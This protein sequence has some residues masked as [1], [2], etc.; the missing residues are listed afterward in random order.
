MVIEQQITKAIIAGIKEL[1]G[2]D[3]TANQVQLQK[4]KKEFKGHLTLVVFP[5]LRQS[6]KS[7]EQTAQEIGAY[8]VAHEPAVAAFNVI[9]GFLNLTVASACWID[10]LNGIAAQPAYGLTPVTEESPLIMIEY[11]SPNTNKPLH[12]G[13]VRNN[14]LGYSL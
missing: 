3:V 8:L 13:H 1:Y 2:A 14:L 4:T 9:K 11:S 6:K 7:T 10:L 12:L 5:F